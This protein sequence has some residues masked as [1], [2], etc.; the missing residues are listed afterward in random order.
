MHPK[1]L[2]TVIII[3]RQLDL[4]IILARNVQ[5]CKYLSQKSASLQM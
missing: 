4:L 3:R 2:Q 1:Q 5:Q